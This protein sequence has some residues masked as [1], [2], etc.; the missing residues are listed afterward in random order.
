MKTPF[1]NYR[2]SFALSRVAVKP[3]TVYVGDTGAAKE[4]G[5]EVLMKM[6]YAHYLV[7]MVVL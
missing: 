5:R 1:L 3:T 6:L 7:V 2:K 4:V